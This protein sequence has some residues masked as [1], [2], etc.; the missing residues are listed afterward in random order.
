MSTNYEEEAFPLAE[1]GTQNW[2]SSLTKL[3]Y[4]TAAAMQGMIQHVTLRDLVDGPSQTNK[5][6]A[7]GAI[8]IAKAT[9]DALA[10]EG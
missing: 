4:F 10:K 1:N 9:L 5:K 8:E 6:I 3:E 7:A 2:Q